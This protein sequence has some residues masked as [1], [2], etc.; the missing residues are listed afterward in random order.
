MHEVELHE[1]EHE[2]L[3]CTKLS[4]AK[5]NYVQHD[6]CGLTCGHYLKPFPPHF[7]LTLFHVYII[8][9]LKLN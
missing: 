9:K 2:R 7:F 3:I 4:S 6:L 1:I 5:L 8:V